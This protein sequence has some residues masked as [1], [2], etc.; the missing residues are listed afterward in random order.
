MADVTPPEP[1]VDTA[2]SNEPADEPCK[3]CCWIELRFEPKPKKPIPSGAQSAGQPWRYKY[4]LKDGGS[5]VKEGEL[6]LD[7]GSVIRAEGIPCGTCSIEIEMPEFPDDAKVKSWRTEWPKYAKKQILKFEDLETNKVHYFD[8]INELPL[9]ADYMAQQMKDNA[10]S[11]I[12]KHIRDLND[13]SQDPPYVPGAGTVRRTAA[14]VDWY[15][16][17]KSGGPWD[18]KPIFSKQPM[19]G[20]VIG[21]W[22]TWGKW[23]YYYDPW[24]NIHYGYVGRAA[25]FD[26]NTLLKG[27]SAANM[28]D[29][30]GTP[31]P[32]QDKEAIQTGIDLY[33]QKATITPDL[34]IQKIESSDTFD[35]RPHSY[36]SA[37][38]DP[39]SIQKR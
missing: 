9:A 1:S 29:N 11:D 13:P 23:E 8:I 5:V 16:Q 17:V 34:L 39:K 22:H 24:S 31:D 30:F 36:N 35:R 25:G 10:G 20:R 19:G 21:R 33:D 4:Q 7:R 37:A 6:D 15:N 28:L 2:F 26:A 12:T 3:G 18:H 38:H 32:P 14:L 27:A